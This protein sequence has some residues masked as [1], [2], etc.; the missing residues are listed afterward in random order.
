MTDSPPSRFPFGATLRPVAPSASCPR[1]VFVLGVYSSALHARWKYGPGPRDYVAALAVD[2]EPSPF[3]N[4]SD[5]E[6]LIARVHP[7]FGT[8]HPAP[9]NGA[10]GKV[11][12][13]EYLFPLDVDRRDCWITDLHNQYLARENQREAFERA[14][15]HARQPAPPWKLPPRIGTLTLSPSRRG[16]LK[17]EFQAARPSWLLTLGEEPL[18][19]LGLPSLDKPGY[20]VPRLV[21]LWGRS[22]CHIAFT[23]PRNAGRLGKSSPAWYE[24]HQQ[25]KHTL[26]PV[27]RAQINTSDQCGAD[28]GQAAV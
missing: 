21:T 20:G 10:S 11:L 7:P 8:L 28:F 15:K 23:H 12:D 5:E 19:A 18:S 16:E 2:N 13:N 26:A 24:V 9:Q 27:L 22:V 17:D 1:R 14:F 25:W 6:E 4:G 3:W